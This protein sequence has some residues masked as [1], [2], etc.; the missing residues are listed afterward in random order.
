[1]NNLS[2]EKKGRIVAI[3]L[4]TATICA[5]IWFGL[6]EGMNER[7]KSIE[8]R[9]I[10]MG[11]KLKKAER[12]TKN[13]LALH[14]ELVDKQAVINQVEDVMAS[15][16]M[17]AWVIAVM[18]RELPAFNLSVPVF[19]RESVGDIGVLT[20]FPYRA[21]TFSIRGSGQFADFG[22]FV[23]H[24]ENTYPFMRIQNIE[25]SPTGLGRSRMDFRFDLVSP[26]KPQPVSIATASN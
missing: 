12:L 2:K 1:M 5:G 15:G 14:E 6:V 16:D 11:E 24:M 7:L 26:I 8:K 10:E 4:M 13:R 22:R 19:S 17:Y 18:N 20:K 9:R 25:L 23:A 3:S 21:A